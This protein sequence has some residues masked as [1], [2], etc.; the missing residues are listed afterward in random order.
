[1]RD[2]P[3]GR[4][5]RRA[6]NASARIAARLNPARLATTLARNVSLTSWLAVVVLVTTIVSL[7]VVSVVS[8]S[9]STEVSNDVFGQRVQALRSLKASDIEFY[10]N[11]SIAQTK[12]LASSATTIEAAERFADAY[13]ELAVA[14]PESAATSEVRDY[15]RSQ[16]VPD[17]EQATGVSISW[18]DLVPSSNAGTILQH[19]Y[20]TSNQV[21][22]GTA[23]LVY[24]AGDGSTWSTV[25]SQYHPGFL[26]ITDRL[27]LDDL[28]IIDPNGGSIVYST[29]K[30]PDFATTLDRGPYSSSSLATV[31]RAVRDSPDAGTVRIADLAPYGAALGE[32]AGFF[33]A[34]ILSGSELV[35]V[36]AIRLPVDEINK[37]MT[38][39]GNWTSEGLGETGESFL[40][41]ADGRMRSIS[42]LYLEDPAAY[43]AAVESSRS[44]SDAAYDAVRALG[45][46]VVFQPAADRDLLERASA[47]SL[48]V[49]E[50]TGYLGR[51]VL[52]SYEPVDVEQ[53][54]WYV[55]VQVDRDEITELGVDYR[56]MI[57]IVVSVFVLVVTFVTVGWARRALDPV[58][59]ISDMLTNA[60]DGKPADEVAKTTG[61]PIV[62]QALAS[63]VN[64]II[65]T[66]ERRRSE[67]E[68]A[69]RERIEVLRGLLP[70]TI[71]RRLE[72][73]DRMVVEQVLQASLVVVSVEGLGAL[74]GAGDVSTSRSILDRV[75]GV[76][77]SIAVENGLERI[78]VVGDL[79]YAGCGLSDPYLD[80]APRALEFARGV[81]R[82]LSEIAG[83]L[84]Y[85]LAPAIGIHSGPVSAGLAGSS[86]L[87]YD[88]WGETLDT[89]SLLAHRALPGEI[90]VSVETRELLPAEKVSAARADKGDPV[91]WHLPP[92][93]GEEANGL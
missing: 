29:S 44:L 43:L 76:L 75:V 65:A 72:V 27:G 84:P 83:E 16:Y 31:V 11:T 82:Q 23:K 25:H 61:G 77:D 32:P 81:Q 56:Q 58:R 85:R 6:I 17:L 88:V 5:V 9:H 54:S 10:L 18:R 62:D 87:V 2:E 41:G 45:T 55:V 28:Y 47:G 91:A 51:D 48:D 14:E 12:A 57:L 86:R 50:T 37:I 52:A 30:A 19:A 8:L 78:K 63:R 33:A 35:G 13:G 20:V 66:S 80:H 68:Q 15:Y 53:L 67:V 34:P 1:V 92:I 38:S 3:D 24:D 73:G 7:L 90:L 59:A 26:D 60:L 40:V 89:T 42:R 79:Y 46:T 64:R 71:T 74:I 69:A 21:D 39:D 22:P 36:L 70:P 93:A 4:G 49:F